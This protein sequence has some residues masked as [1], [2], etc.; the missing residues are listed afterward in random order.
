MVKNQHAVKENT[1]IVKRAASCDFYLL[2]YDNTVQ[3]KI[4]KNLFSLKKIRVLNKFN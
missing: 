1:Q 3:F 2:T 4:L